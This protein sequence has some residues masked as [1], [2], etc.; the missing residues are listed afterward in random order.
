MVE[1]ATI[2]P[3]KT[4]GAGFMG[5]LAMLKGALHMDMAVLALVFHSLLARN[6]AKTS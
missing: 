4:C 6:F 3:A 2:G 1:I 5:M